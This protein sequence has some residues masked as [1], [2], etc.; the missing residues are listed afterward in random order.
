MG[1]IRLSLMLGVAFCLAAPSPAAETATVTGTVS[2]PKDG[3][4]PSDVVVYLKGQIGAPSPANATIDQKNETFV[5][6]V[7]AVPVG[8]RVQFLNSDPFLHNVFSTSATK[9]FDLGMFPMGESREVTFDKAGVVEVRCNVHPKMQA[10]IVVVENSFFAIPDA[11]GGFQLT[12]VPPGRYRLVAWHPTLEPAETWV[13]L[14][15][16]KVRNVSLKLAER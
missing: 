10:F 2:L 4:T 16:A 5:P 8:S 1:K 9:R 12:G 15:E 11:Q 6:H 3:G 13:N 14:D 7:I